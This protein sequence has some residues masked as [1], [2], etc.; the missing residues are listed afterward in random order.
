MFAVV[1][2]FLLPL[3]VLLSLEGWL[4]ATRL[5]R[6]SDRILSGPAEARKRRGAYAVAAATVLTIALV[7]AAARIAF[8]I[9]SR[10][11]RWGQYGFGS[12]ITL[13]RLSDVSDITTIQFP[14]G[15]TLLDGEYLGGWSQYLIAKIAMD[16]SDVPRFLEQAPFRG[17]RETAW[18]VEVPQMIQRGWDLE[19]IGSY[20]SA[21]GI[22]HAA[23]EMCKVTISLDDPDTA[24]VY[25]YWQSQ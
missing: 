13:D 24:V 2:M 10:Q 4:L 19:A 16:R 14:A 21:Q 23:P 15:G 6:H 20:V 12:P 11:L 8:P 18:R 1:E 22:V 7:L 17:Q 3:G 9:L 25:L 5:R